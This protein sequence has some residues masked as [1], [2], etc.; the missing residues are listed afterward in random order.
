M[1]QPPSPAEAAV[2]TGDEAQLRALHEQADLCLPR[3]DRGWLLRLAVDHNQPRMLQLLLD[4][5]FD[6]DARVPVEEDDGRIVSTWG[7]PLY[8]CSRRLKHEM[9]EM[10]LRHGADPNGQ[11][12]ASGTPLSEAYGQR[13]EGMIALLIRYGGKSNATKAGFVRISPT[14]RY[15]RW[16][17]ERGRNSPFRPS[18]FL[19]QAQ[20][21][22]AFTF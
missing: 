18:T 14:V 7:I 15:T 5:G 17:Q 22:A 11:V 1:Q 13:D 6:P 3:D 9:A 2:I 20:I 4:L 8:Q 10:L 16:A 19:N 12:Y 21:L